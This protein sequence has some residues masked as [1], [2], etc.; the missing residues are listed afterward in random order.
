MSN[1]VT[2]TRIWNKMSVEERIDRKTGAM[3]LYVK[4]VQ[5]ASSSNTNKGWYELELIDDGE[6][7]WRNYNS[8]NS[9]NIVTLKEFQK[10]FKN[11]GVPVYYKD[12]SDLLNDKSTYNSEKDWYESTTSLF[13]VK[14]PGLSSPQTGKKVDNKGVNVTDINPFGSQPEVS[15]TKSSK[16]SVDTSDPNSLYES[17]N[18]YFLSAGGSSAKSLKSSSEPFL[19]Y[20]SAQFTS[21][22][23]DYIQIAA[24]QYKAPTAA[25]NYQDLVGGDRLGPNI[26]TVALPMQPNLT[27]TSTTRWGGDKLNAIEAALATAAGKGIEGIVNGGLGQG[28]KSTAS[29]IVGDA[30]RLL[31]ESGNVEFLKAYFAG[32]AIGKNITARATSQIINPNLELLFESPELRT[33]S[34][35]FTLTPRDE[36]ESLNIRKII[37]FFKKNM[38]PHITKEKL[39]L[40]TPNIFKL[41][42]MFSGGSEHPFL[43]KIKPCAMTSFDVDYAPGGRY[44]T[45]SDGSMTQY[46]LSM[47]FGELTPVYESD[48]ESAGGTGY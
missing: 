13:D 32:Q 4:T 41:E 16:K 39:F 28:F 42:Y 22:A 1:I 11:S 17:A 12:R 23:Y 8:S 19:R 48:Q 44:S 21:D 27:E 37:R 31:N 20:P 15:N 40:Y 33:F 47:S 38:N 2:R 43:N 6:L 35:N 26:G 24:H 3:D 14:T 46:T 18:S 36:E 10:I 34:F 9:S 7:F 30:K 25:A 29:S 5:V 45:Y